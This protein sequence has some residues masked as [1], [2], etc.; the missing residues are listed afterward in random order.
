[1]EALDGIPENAAL[2]QQAGA[3][4]II[5][6]DIRRRDPAAQ[7]GG[8]QGDVRRPATRAST[9]RGSRPFAGSPPIRPG[10]SASTATTG[11]LEPGKMADVVVWSGDP[12]SVYSKAER[13]YNEGWL[14]FDRSD[15]KRRLE[16][17]FNLGT[18][19]PGVG[20]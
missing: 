19:A 2:L 4:A 16:T 1:M 20:Q 18:A 3:R 7:P 15:S 9:S 14:V 11:T 5:H 13:V 6:S 8:G 12:S 17:D 10:R